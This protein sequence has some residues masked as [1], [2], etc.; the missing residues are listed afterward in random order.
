MQLAVPAPADPALTAR[1]WWASVAAGFCALGML[2]GLLGCSDGP[3]PSQAPVCADPEPVCEIGAAR[4]AGDTVEICTPDTTACGQWIGT[5]TCAS[6]ACLEGTCRVISCDPAREEQ[7]NGRDDD[8]D[9]LVDELLS[10]CEGSCTPACELGDMRCDTQGNVAHCQLRHGCLQWGEPRGCGAAMVCVGQ[11]CVPARDCHDQDGDGA[12]V[13]TECVRQDCNDREPL[14]R[15]GGIE[16]CDGLDN[17]CD[18]FVDNNPDCAECDPDNCAPGTLACVGRDVVACVSGPDGCGVRDLVTRCAEGEVCQS[19]V[20]AP[21]S[22]DDDRLEPNDDLESARDVTREILVGGQLCRDDP[23]WFELAA[24]QAG[25]YIEVEMQP[26]GPEADLD[27]F[28]WTPE[29]RVAG[30]MMAGARERIVWQAPAA[31]SVFVEVVGHDGSEGSYTI[32]WT[33]TG[34]RECEDDGM[35]PNDTHLISSRL[36]GQSAFTATI[37]SGDDDWYGPLDVAEG[38]TVMIQVTSNEFL[39]TLDASLVDPDTLEVIAR[40]LRGGVG[41]NFGYVAQL[42]R[43]PL[44]R[45]RGGDLRSFGAYGVRVVLAD[46]GACVQDPDEP[47]DRRTQAGPIVPTAYLCTGD[48]DWYELGDLAGGT[49]LTIRAQ[50]TGVDPEIE[51]YAGERL[52]ATGSGPGRDETVRY[53][54]PFGL[55]GPHWVRVTAWGPWFG[56]YT[57]HVDLEPPPECTEDA[58]EPN[59]EPGQAT[60]LVEDERLEGALCLGS[61]D[62][63]RLGRIERQTDGD[64]L[65]VSVEHAGAPEDVTVR[66]FDGGAIAATAR[67]VPSGSLL[68]LP[69]P[70]GDRLYTVQIAP[71]PEAATGYTVSWHLVGPDPCIDDD[72]EPNDTREEAARA[73]LTETVMGAT[74]GGNPDF[75]V[76]TGA[77]PAPGVRVRATVRFVHADGDLDVRLYRGDD[78]VASGTSVTDDEDTSYLVPDDDQS[79]PFTAEIFGF[80]GAENTYE[81]TFTLE[82]PE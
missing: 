26:D 36:T 31:V 18:G 33:V 57:F 66:L 1:P 54:V 56:P 16:V 14:E 53:R 48:A 2:A 47:N 44:L 32:N 74:C 64:R 58:H 9:G 61:A 40:P 50:G 42:D 73:A 30:S 20:C 68:D 76:L 51:L 45:V 65:V 80:Q 7:C 12:G 46:P 13:G 27:L 82:E 37:C 38:T 43:S 4:C 8:C 25:D 28:L 29:G 24:L 34:L 17:D 52:V 41:Q 77:D 49:E 70:A 11:L 23:D 39:G 35:E 55:R 59:D 81:I 22:C 63:F 67:S 15:P 6:D 72:H 10:G 78:N 3:G 62:W 19:G 75:F 71:G 60:S 79:L 21:Y 69:L 5:Q